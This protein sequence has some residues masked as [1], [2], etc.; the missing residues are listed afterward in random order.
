MKR[1]T[2]LIVA[3]TL[4]AHINSNAQISEAP[5]YK[6]DLGVSLGSDGI[7]I[8]VS[9]PINEMLSIRAG[10][11]GLPYFQI[12]VSF[13]FEDNNADA[14]GSEESSTEK[15]IETLRNATGLNVDEKVTMIATP[16]W[17]TARVLCDIKPLEN[18]NWHFTAGMYLSPSTVAK[19]A[20]APA[21]AS[22]VTAI[23]IYN[24]LYDQAVD[25]QPLISMGDIDIYSPGIQDRIINHGRLGVPL[26]SFSDGTEY[27][28]YPSEEAS[29][30]AKVKVP[31]IKPYTGAGYDGN[32]ISGNSDFRFSIDCGLMLLYKTPSIVMHD[33]TDIVHDL[34]SWNGRLHSACSILSRMYAYPVISFRISHKLF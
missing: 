1:I 18:K 25:G 22:T 20:N 3:A 6:V 30:T 29:V 16:T 12:P 31:V 2:F 4:F 14:A 10:F 26:G 11:V 28:L 8:D 32:L 15:M 33:G 21:D 7:G 34:S 13:S 23:N 19:V 9:T 24:Y 5:N 27:T 17:K